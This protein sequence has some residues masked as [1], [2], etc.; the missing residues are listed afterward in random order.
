MGS[1][2]EAGRRLRASFAGFGDDDDDDE[3]FSDVVDA[4]DVVGG[5]EKDSRQEP[6]QSPEEKSVR[7]CSPARGAPQLANHG[8]AKQDGSPRTPPVRRLRGSTLVD[9]FM[10]RSAG[11]RRGDGR[12]VSTPTA[13]A[14][15]ADLDGFSPPAVSLRQRRSRRHRNEVEQRSPMEKQPPRVDMSDQAALA[16]QTAERVKGSGYDDSGRQG[17]RTPGQTLPRGAEV[18]CASAA[19]SDLHLVE[20]ALGLAP[21]ALSCR[22]APGAAKRSTAAAPALAPLVDVDDEQ[23]ALAM[24]VADEAAGELLRRRAT[25]TRCARSR[26]KDRF[27]EAINFV[28]ACTAYLSV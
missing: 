13:P 26:S 4:N 9:G 18:V 23:V 1:D 19:Y 7:E 12:G 22:T 15:K 14:T 28:G 5:V 25:R 11:G 3:D 8:K 20:S 21:G 10:M 6:R 2:D 24:R 17:R 27:G 16:Q